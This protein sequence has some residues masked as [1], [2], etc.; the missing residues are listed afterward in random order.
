M[1][2]FE[3]ISRCLTK[4]AKKYPKMPRKDI[5][6]ICEKGLIDDPRIGPIVFLLF[7]LVKRAPK[8]KPQDLQGEARYEYPSLIKRMKRKIWAKDPDYISDLDFTPVAET[9]WQ[10]PIQK[11]WKWWIPK[12]GPGELKTIRKIVFRRHPIKDTEIYLQMV[13]PM[14]PNPTSKTDVRGTLIVSN[15][16]ANNLLRYLFKEGVEFW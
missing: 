16:R 13:N 10:M 5:T 6:Y 8:V 7:D 11:V 9:M 14:D 4:T 1:N 15:P 12:E 3:H 2:N